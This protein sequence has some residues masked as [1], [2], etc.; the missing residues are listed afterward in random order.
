MTCN[1]GLET[2]LG[3]AKRPGSVRIMVTTPAEAAGDYAF[4]QALVASGMDCMRIN[5]AHDEADAW[6]RMVGTCARRSR[7]AGRTLFSSGI[8][9][10]R[11]CKSTQENLENP[12]QAARIPKAS[13]YQ[14]KSTVQTTPAHHQHAEPVQCEVRPLESASNPFLS[15]FVSKRATSRT[16]TD[17]EY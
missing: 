5:C 10:L 8:R 6:V 13:F 16:R 2:V 4:V 9:R 17:N 7:A 3:P 11:L 1:C 14:A 12:W 15:Q